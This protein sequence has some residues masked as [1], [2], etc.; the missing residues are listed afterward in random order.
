MTAA[1]LLSHLGELNVKVRSD[2]GQ[3]I[4]TGAKGALTADLRAE[5]SEHKAE[6]LKLLNNRTV[7]SRGKEPR[8]QPVPREGKLRLSFAQQRLWFLD[9]YEPDKSFYNI[10]FALRLSGPLDVPALERSI[11]EIIRR[12]E[13][14]RTTFPVYEGEPVQCINLPV[15][16]PLSVID[17][18]D[19][20]ASDREDQAR[21]LADEEARRHFDLARG[22]LFRRSLIR[23]AKN[24]HILL[25]TLHHIVS[26]GWSV[27]VLYRELSVLY[28]AF[29]RAQPSPL[30]DLPIQY[31][32]FAVWQRQWLTGNILESQLS[33]WKKQL[34]GIPAVLNLPTDHPRPAVQSYRG[35]RHSGLV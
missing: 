29:S 32:D 12:H 8:L 27:G 13:A 28:G 1:E 6:I 14:L 11:N 18:S 33:Y 30:A 3:L 25:L 4:F 5:L 15:E 24:D 21:R 7:S 35:A 9:Q 2:N 10:P 19:V 17:L 16:H 20:P 34:A 31:A 23:L 22:P 26:D